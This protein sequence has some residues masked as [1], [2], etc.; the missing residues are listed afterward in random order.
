MKNTWLHS[1]ILIAL[2]TLVL[3]FATTLRVWAANLFLAAP[4]TALSVLGPGLL[5]GWFARR[6]PLL[7][8]AIAG[9]LAPIVARGILFPNIELPSLAGEAAATA[10]TVAVASFAGR[11]LRFRMQPNRIANCVPPAPRS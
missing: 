5:L 4:V 11:A 6:H 7:V 3:A 10:M 1:L 9:A 8:G 2:A